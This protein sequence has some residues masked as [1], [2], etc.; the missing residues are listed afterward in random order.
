MANLPS[1]LPSILRDAGLKVVEVDGWRDRGRPGSFAPVGVLCHH[2]ATRKSSSDAAVV[3]LLRVGRSDLPGPL[4][5][6]GLARNG[7]VYLIAAG[8]SNHAG[9]AKSS[10]T[11]AAGDGNTLYIGIEAFND[12]VGEPWPIVQRDAYELLAAVLSVKVTGNSVNT[13]RGH[14]ET[15]V[16]GKIDPTFN[17]SAFRDAVGAEMNRLKNP[18]APKPEVP[19]VTWTTPIDKDPRP[20]AGA[21]TLQTATANVRELPRHDD[22]IEATF[23]RAATGCQLAGFQETGNDVYVRAM[24]AA[25]ENHGCHGLSGDP[26]HNVS[27]AYDKKLFRHVASDYWK[28]FDGEAGISHTRHGLW[29]ELEMLADPSFHIIVTSVHYPSGGFSP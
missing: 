7:T 28:L 18:T 23:N 14:K 10:G 16:T 12:G 25:L 27:M 19:A 13:V 6:I 22:T 15:S 2:T 26:Q 4:S 5:Q 21:I 29:V 1:N 24:R 11:V 17:M 20:K 9:R 8:R 3:R